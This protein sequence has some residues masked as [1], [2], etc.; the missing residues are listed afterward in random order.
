M[1]RG[2]DRVVFLLLRRFC[3]VPN[4]R[5]EDIRLDAQLNNWVFTL[6]RQIGKGKEYMCPKIMR[7]NIESIRGKMKILKTDSYLNM[8]RWG[9][10]GYGQGCSKQDGECL[11]LQ[12]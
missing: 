2:N 4:R 1:I 8:M 10:E 7:K 9:R 12:V 3:G 6:K 11:L 5:S